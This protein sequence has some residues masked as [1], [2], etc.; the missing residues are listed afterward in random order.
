MDGANTVGGEEK[1]EDLRNA[2]KC[3]NS[4]EGHFRLRSAEGQQGNLRSAM[5]T[6]LW[7][8]DERNGAA[9]SSTFME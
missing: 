5:L 3:V 1:R 4:L 6:V 2:R 7:K 9:E 8:W